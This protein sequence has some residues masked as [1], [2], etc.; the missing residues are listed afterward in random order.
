MSGLTRAALCLSLLITLSSCA[1]TAQQSFPTAP[2]LAGPGMD[3]AV[4]ARGRKLFT[5]SCTECHVARSIAGYSVEQWHHYVAIM[6]PRARL[7]PDERAALETYL[8]TAR[9]FVPPG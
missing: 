1:G 9:E 3:V 8:V 4:L 5:T 2:S 7:K 6:A